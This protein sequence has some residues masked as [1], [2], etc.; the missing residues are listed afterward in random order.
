MAFF[1]SRHPATPLSAGMV[2]H[3]VNDEAAG[4]ARKIVGNLSTPVPP[5][6]NDRSPLMLAAPNHV[7]R[8]HMVEKRM[9]LLG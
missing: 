7:L 1:A 2:A 3:P 6:M 8:L 4:R 9:R 5:K